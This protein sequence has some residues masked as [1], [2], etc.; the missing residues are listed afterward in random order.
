MSEVLEWADRWPGPEIGRGEVH[1]GRLQVGEAGRFVDATLS[2]DEL[3]RASA[4]H[5]EADRD[6][7]ISSRSALRS[8]LG[9][10]LGIDPRSLRLITDT[11]GKPLLADPPQSSLHFNVSHAN[12][13]IVIALSGESPIGVDVEEVRTDIPHREMASRFFSSKELRDLDCRPVD[14]QFDHFFSVWTRKEAYLKGIGIGLSLPPDSFSVTVEGQDPT[15]VDDPSRSDRW[16][17]SAIDVAHG[18]KSALALP[19][20]HWTIR[21][22]EVRGFDG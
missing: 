1:V 6:R 17:T 21:P 5:F 7:Y 3:E 19:R 15:P 22:F 11:H 20:N 12:T 10:Y 13:L 8:L 2:S 14:E 18:F 9:A 4:F 16:W